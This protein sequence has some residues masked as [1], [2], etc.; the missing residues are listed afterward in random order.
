MG[1]K[2]TKLGLGQTSCILLGLEC[3]KIDFSNFKNNSIV[4]CLVKEA[5][6]EDR[7]DSR[8]QEN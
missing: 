4:L 2:A 1:A 5:T 6:T 3:F 7:N 8:Q